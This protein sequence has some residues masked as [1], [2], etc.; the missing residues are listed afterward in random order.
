MTT[1]E[2]AA[3]WKVSETWVTILCKDNRIPGAVKEGG[4]W[5]IPANAQKPDDARVTREKGKARFKFID[6][7]AGIGGFRMAFQ[8]LGGKCVFSSEWDEQA[9]KTY[10]SNYGEVP[11]DRKSVV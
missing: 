9:R 3:L 7:F 2:I 6:L 8:N 1:K 10:Y 4:R 11:L 5:N